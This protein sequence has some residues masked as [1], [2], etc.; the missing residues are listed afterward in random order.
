MTSTPLQDATCNDIC[1]R[2]QDYEK[3][4]NISHLLS[5]NAE[6]QPVGLVQWDHS[7]A[8]ELSTLADNSSRFPKSAQQLIDAIKKNR[9][10]QK[11]LRS[12]LTQIESKIEEN[13]KLKERV[14][15]LKDFQVSC[16]KITGRSLSI[17]K[18][19][20]IQLISAR[21][22][23]TSKDP[24]VIICLFAILCLYFLLF[25]E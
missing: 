6:M 7:D 20:R 19:P 8:N 23:R 14:K 4:G 22:S 11:F 2:F 21:K 3:A 25:W 18:D 12:K 15:I 16:K 17:N 5:G 13:K 1:E 10:Y 24:E 9:S